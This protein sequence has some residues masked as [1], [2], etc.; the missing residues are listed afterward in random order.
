MLIISFRPYPGPVAAANIVVKNK[1]TNQFKNEVV[2]TNI[3]L[4]KTFL[5]L[6][7]VFVGS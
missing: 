1:E 7:K 5:L 6:R 4:N 3:D 2:K